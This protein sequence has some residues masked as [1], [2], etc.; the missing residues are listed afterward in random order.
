MSVGTAAAAADVLVVE[1]DRDIRDS[2]VELLADEG[3]VA[4]GAEHGEAA[5]RVLRAGRVPR[6]ILLDLMMP[7]MDGFAFRE[8]QGRE[9]AW[10][11]IPV[12][13]MSADGQVD[14]KKARAG[15]V[16]YLKKPVDIHELLAVVKRC[17]AAASK[18]TD[19]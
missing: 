2:I 1:D 18:A 10:A 9:P 7:V 15:A 17:L 5:L 14:A 3:L 11:G 8:A 19:L 16:E 13:V 12:V 6:L 4:V